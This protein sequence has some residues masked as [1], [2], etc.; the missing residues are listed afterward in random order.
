M[1]QVVREDRGVAASQPEV[2]GQVYDSSA[3]ALGEHGLLIFRSHTVAT[4]E[5]SAVHDGDEVRIERHAGAAQFTHNAT[6]VRI[7]AIERAL[8]ELALRHSSGSARRLLIV[9]R[10][11]HAHPYDLGGAFRV[12]RHLLG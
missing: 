6:P 12:A 11:D 7:V 2:R 5:D 1:T 3:H 8:H 4:Y 9:L 10:T